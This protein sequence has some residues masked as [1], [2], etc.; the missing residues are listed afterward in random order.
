MNSIVKYRIRYTSQCRY[1]IDTDLKSCQKNL[2]EYLDKIISD[3]NSLR[4]RKLDELREEF[5]VRDKYM[6]DNFESLMSLSD[7]IKELLNK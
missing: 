1:K 7:E 2:N 4:V 3:I 5:E 6:I